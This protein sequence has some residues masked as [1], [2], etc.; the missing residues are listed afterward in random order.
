MKLGVSKSNCSQ[1]Q[2]YRKFITL[3]MSSL[4]CIIY[5]MES[6]ESFPLT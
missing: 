5:I 2:N 4:L 6:L 1:I 3:I